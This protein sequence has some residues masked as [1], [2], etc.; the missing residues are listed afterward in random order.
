MYTPNKI[1]V[2]NESLNDPLT[3][4]IIDKASSLNPNLEITFSDTSKPQYPEDFD[5]GDKYHSMKETLVLSHR[6]NSFIELF[7]SPGYIVEKPTIMIKSLFHCNAKCTYCYLGKTF[8]RH[9]YQRVY[10]N[11]E[12]LEPEMKNEMFIYPGIMTLLSAISIN[13]K[14]TL[15][16]IPFEFNLVANMFRDKLSRKGKAKLSY[17]S[18]FNYLETNLAEWLKKSGEVVDENTMNAIKSE[19]PEIFEKDKALPFSFN[20]SEYTDIANIDH[21]AGHLEYFMK[22]LERNPEFNIRFTTKSAQLGTLLNHTGDNRMKVSMGFNTDYAH[23]NY[24]EGTSAIQE[25][26]DM[27]KMLQKKGGYKLGIRIE[28]IIFYNGY[29]Q[30][31]IQLVRKLASEIDFTSVE[32]ITIGALITAP[33]LNGLINRF[34]PDTDL[35]SHDL[36][37][38]VDHPDKLR[39]PF[40]DRFDIYEKIISEFGKFTEVPVKLGAENPEMWDALKIDSSI[41]E[42]CSYQYKPKEDTVNE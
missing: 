21:I 16:K 12:Q 23:D 17:D 10:T 3:K 33:V 31:Y 25:R 14:E 6:S 20:I 24:E 18:V 30:E 9:Q 36:E 7:A 15:M 13:R 37:S 11:L 42:S 35:T 2:C 29:E 41:I 4:D 19:L 39:Y 8:A 5:I 32:S 40:N 38:T 22:I 26:I 34:F 1:I 28:P 27:I